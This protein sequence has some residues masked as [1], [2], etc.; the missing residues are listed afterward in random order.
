MP[1]EVIR[2]LLEMLEYECNPDRRWELVCQ[3]REQLKD[4]PV[5]RYRP[6]AQA[7]DERKRA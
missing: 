7:R 2:E 3:L 1:S 5:P 4:V 6:G